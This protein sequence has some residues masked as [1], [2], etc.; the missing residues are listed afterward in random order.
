M[1]VHL[2]R[3]VNRRSDFLKDIPCQ[4]KGLVSLLGIPRWIGLC[5]EKHAPME[6]IVLLINNVTFMCEMMCIYWQL[7][8]H[9]RGPNWLW[10]KIKKDQVHIFVKFATSVQQE[11]GDETGSR[12]VKHTRHLQDV[13]P[14]NHRAHVFMGTLA[15]GRCFRKPENITAKKGLPGGCSLL[16]HKYRCLRGKFH[17]PGEGQNKQETATET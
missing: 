16:W 3:Q 13:P 1:H 4:L 5:S 2:G 14:G 8:S 15:K 12:P 9:T 10:S 6:L 17:Q 7:L 11:A